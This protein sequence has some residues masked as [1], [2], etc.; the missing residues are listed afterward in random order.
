MTP[1]DRP[2]TNDDVSAA[3]AP[4]PLVC[5]AG[6]ARRRPW[7]PQTRRN[8]GR[9]G[10]AAA[11]VPAARS[12]GRKGRVGEQRPIGAR[13]W[14]PPRRPQ[15]QR[16][17]AIRHVAGDDRG[18][19]AARD[20]A[21]TSGHGV[22]RLVQLLVPVSHLHHRPRAGSVRKGRSRTLAWRAGAIPPARGDGGLGDHNGG[23]GP[24]VGTCGRGGGT[25]ERARPAVETFFWR[26][27]SGGR[28]LKTRNYLFWR[29]SARR[30]RGASAVSSG[31][32]RRGV[33]R[34]G[35]IQLPEPGRPAAAAAGSRPWGR[36][37]SNCQ[38]SARPNSPLE[39]AFPGSG[40]GLRIAWVL[41][42]EANSRLPAE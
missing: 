9:G 17:C 12:V 2:P 28:R 31:E 34:M 35:R 37:L 20:A 29:P 3:P 23:R 6:A 11:P 41:F 27:A 30:L 16:A 14:G 42:D 21:P 4:S 10:P 13:W 15:R 32:G 33:P 36:R 38:S 5:V 1:T 26:T 18:G 7:R 19:P 22:R 25:S 39:S 8:R 40:R 24:S